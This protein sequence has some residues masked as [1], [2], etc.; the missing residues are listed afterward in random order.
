MP[1]IPFD[2]ALQLSGKTSNAP[3]NVYLDRKGSFEGIYRAVTSSVMGIP[4]VER[5]DRDGK[6]FLYCPL[7]VLKRTSEERDGERRILEMTSVSRGSSSGKVY[8][9]KWGKG[10]DGNVDL[11]TSNAKILL[12]I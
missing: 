8:W 10:R 12:S 3:L 1:T 2:S 7:L 4:T 5:A 6:V 9:G 11:K